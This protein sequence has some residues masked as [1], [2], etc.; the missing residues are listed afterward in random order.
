MHLFKICDAHARLKSNYDT[1]NMQNTPP[2]Q[3]YI[4]NLDELSKWFIFKKRVM[5]QKSYTQPHTFSE[6]KIHKEYFEA[7]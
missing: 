5:S 3:R 1:P 7:F 2:P 6:T 4:F